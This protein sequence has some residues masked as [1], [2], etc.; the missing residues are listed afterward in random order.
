[1]AMYKPQQNHGRR[2]GPIINRSLNQKSWENSP[3]VFLVF[4]HHIFFVDS[5]K[6]PFPP[7]PPKS[8]TSIHIHQVSTTTI[9]HPP[10]S[11]I[12]HPLSTAFPP[13]INPVGGSSPDVRHG[14]CFSKFQAIQVL[15]LGPTPTRRFWR[16]QI[17]PGVIFFSTKKTKRGFPRAG[18]LVCFFFSSGIFVWNVGE[19]KGMQ[20]RIGWHVFV[21]F[22]RKSLIQGDIIRC[23]RGNTN[24]MHLVS[25][26]MKQNLSESNIARLQQCIAVLYKFF[27]KMHDLS[28]RKIILDKKNLAIGLE[29]LN[30]RISLEIQPISLPNPK[31]LSFKHHLGW[32]QWQWHHKTWRP[33]L[34]R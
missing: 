33:K 4:L 31:K 13:T 30:L 12:L 7:K 25:C 20:F 14:I 22:I 19:I 8:I 11:T 29:A 1:M 15:S 18:F 26:N 9:R 5:P 32:M 2:M 17:H 27:K 21:R 16:R 10:S 34:V 6:S 3:W 23:F 28:W 24:G